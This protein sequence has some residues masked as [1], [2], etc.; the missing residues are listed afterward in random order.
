MQYLT[1]AVP[2]IPATVEAAKLISRSLDPDTGGYA[3]YDLVAKDANGV[4]FAVYG[5]LV[6][7]DFYAKVTYLQQNPDKLL[8]LINADIA[9]RWSENPAMALDQVTLF[10]SSMVMS[11][12]YGVT[13]G[14][15]DLKLTVKQT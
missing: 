5:T 11:T 9:L 2:N 1:T 3:A 10:T 6:T 4:E 14:L 15:D 12:E 8:Q 7:D 13:A